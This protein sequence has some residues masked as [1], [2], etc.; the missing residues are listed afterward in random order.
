MGRTRYTWFND[1]NHPMWNLIR[2]VVV[3]VPLMVLLNIGYDRNWTAADWAMLI[4]PLA[5]LGAFDFVKKLITK[6]KVD[7]QSPPTEEV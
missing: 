7:D 5:S 1:S 3:M 4:T 6:S 2:Q